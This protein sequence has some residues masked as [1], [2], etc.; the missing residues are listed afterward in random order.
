MTWEEKRA[1][2]R[3]YNAGSRKQWPEH[4]PPYPPESI[5]RRLMEAVV[6]A[7]NEADKI[8][9]M[10]GPEDEVVVVLGRLID[11]ADAAS[12]AVDRWLKTYPLPEAAR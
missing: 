2:A 11:E 5:V 3:G 12:E 6:A 9:A 4:M 7:R 1:Y 10:F 8:Q